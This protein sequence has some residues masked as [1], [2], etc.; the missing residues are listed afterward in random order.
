MVQ[1]QTVAGGTLGAMS[2]SND[3]FTQ[4]DICERYRASERRISVAQLADLWGCSR[5]H[6]YNLV[7]R[8][9]IAAIRVG[10]LIRFRPQDV[11]AYEESK[12][13]AHEP[14]SPP[15]PSPNAQRA[16]V[17]SATMSSGG[18]AAPHAGF[19]AAQAILRRRAA[20]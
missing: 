9:E 6:V 18:N 14:K 15:I 2:M 19:L 20:S 17:R 11:D 5:Q 7:A 12:C 10:N 4:A 1:R 8:Q 3:S 16:T 13:R